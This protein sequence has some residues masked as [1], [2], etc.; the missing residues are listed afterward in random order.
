MTTVR[1]CVDLCVCVCGFMCLCVWIYVFVR[2][3][4]YRE[5]VLTYGLWDQLRTDKG[6]EWCLS[7]FVNEKLSHRYCTRKPPHLQTTSRKV[8]CYIILGTVNPR[9]T[10]R[11]GTETPLEN[12][13]I[14]KNVLQSSNLT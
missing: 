6:K 3:G 5:V 2:P 8:G 4:T 9:L 12:W 11:L 7:L 10:E 1:V 14:E 13:I